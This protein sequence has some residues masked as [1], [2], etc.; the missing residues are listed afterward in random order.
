MLATVDALGDDRIVCTSTDRRDWRWPEMLEAA[1]QAAGLLGG[2]CGDGLDATLVIAEYRDVRVR[3]ARHQGPL[4]LEA[5]LGRRVLQFR[6]CTI[7]ARAAH[8]DVLLDGTVA[9]APGGHPGT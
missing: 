1:A 4:R 9:L 5:S 7:T 8:G 3:A 2:L 6:L